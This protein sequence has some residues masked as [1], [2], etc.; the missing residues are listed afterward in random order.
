MYLTTEN[1]HKTLLTLTNG[2]LFQSESDYPF[3]VKTVTSLAVLSLPNTTITLDRLLQRACTPQTWHTP[4]QQATVTQYQHLYHYLQQIPNLLIYKTNDVVA[5]I[6]V[7][8]PT[9]PQEWVV[10]STKVIET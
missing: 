5:E 10:L 1:T 8:L 9:A 6:T 7:L 3:E 4:A 2:L